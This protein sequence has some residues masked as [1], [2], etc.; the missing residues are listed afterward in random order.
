MRRRRWP[1]L[2][3]PATWLIWTLT[4]AG[5]AA[6]VALVLADNATLANVVLAVV[7]LVVAAYQADVTVP[8]PAELWVERQAELGYSDLILY[9]D[10]NA[11]GLPDGV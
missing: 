11:P 10:I 3:S 2:D 6:T 9:R 8:S 5:I 4:A 1:R 7:V